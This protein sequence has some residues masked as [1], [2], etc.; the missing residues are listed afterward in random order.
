LRRSPAATRLPLLSSADLAD[1][2]LADAAQAVVGEVAGR[3][4]TFG[5]LNLLAE[6]HR[7][8]HGVRFS[9]P[10][11]RLAVAERVTDLAV[12]R[13][14]VIT[15]P[16]LCHTPAQYLRADGS[17]RLRPTHHVLYTSQAVLE[18]CRASHART[19][20]SI[21]AA[22]VVP[23]CSPR[24]RGREPGGSR[25]R[26]SEGG[27]R[28]LRLGLWPRRAGRSLGGMA[29]ELS[30]MA[31][32]VARRAFLTLA[33]SMSVLIG[34]GLATPAHV[35]ALSLGHVQPAD[36]SS[37]WIPT[38]AP[39]PSSLPSGEPVATMQL[40]STSCS[41][42]DFCV[43]VGYVQDASSD[44]YPLVETYQ[45]GVWTPSLLALP[46]NT[47]PGNPP[48][49]QLF[50]VSCPVDGT[51]A[52]VGAYNVWVPSEATNDGMGL[53]AN[54]SGGD[55]ATSAAPYPADLGVWE[56]HLYSVSCSSA[57]VCDAIGQLYDANWSVT[58]QLPVLALY[59]LSDGTWQYGSLP[60]PP[61]AYWDLQVNS[62]S[63]AD[64]ADCV[65]VGYYE[66]D[67]QD[68]YGVAYTL[69]SGQW[70]ETVLPSPTTAPPDIE[71]TINLTSVD[72]PQVDYC[73]AVGAVV[74]T[75][76]DDMP[77]VSIYDGSAWTSSEESLPADAPAG[78][79]GWLTGVSCASGGACNAVGPYVY[80][81]VYYGM[82]LTQSA[83]GW[84]AA[85]A[86][87]PPGFSN[88]ARASA[89]RAT[90]SSQVPPGGVGCQAEGFCAAGLTDGNNNE[91]ILETEQTSGLTYVSGVS[92]AKG[93]AGTAVKITG[94]GF[95]ASD[96]V[97]F[98]KVAASSETFV[99]S[100]EIEASVPK[101]VDGSTV[102]V[103][104]SDGALTSG[105]LP[106]DV[107]TYDY[108]HKLSIVVLG[109][110][111]ALPGPV[112]Y[113]AKA[114]GGSGSPT[115]TIRISDSSGTSCSLKL[116]GGAGQCTMEASFSA[117]ANLMRWTYGGSAKYDHATGQFTQVA[118]V[119]A[120]PFAVG[121]ASV[122]AAGTVTYSVEAAGASP[123]PTGLVAVADGAGNDCTAE[124]DNGQG[125]CQIT[126]MPGKSYAVAATY[127]G[128]FNYVSGAA[129]VHLG[130]SSGAAVLVLSAAP[131]VTGP[132]TYEVALAG[133]AGVPTGTVS[134]ADGAGGTCT[135]ELSGG[136]GSCEISERAVNGT[137]DVSATYNGNTVYPATS[138]TVTEPILPAQPSIKGTVSY[139][140]STHLATYT[141]KL[142]GVKGLYPTGEVLVSVPDV[143]SCQATV[144]SGTGRCQ[145]SE[146]SG[147]TR[148]ATVAYGGD[149]NYVALTITVA[150]Q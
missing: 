97:Y 109:P 25:R 74:D 134:I 96:D 58:T 3:R 133:D 119:A 121:V 61:A 88:G 52:A 45:D 73:V 110:A 44:T 98:G 47:Q 33:A 81:S 34:T 99:S 70:T 127:D 4:A 118:K 92:P 106:S 89:I 75:S 128:D 36:S 105:Q 51:C 72:C 136:T 55:W 42:A 9:S 115:G 14:L 91:G 53:L 111:D 38:A 57:N 28:P 22:Q 104:V 117:G 102:N 16:P 101:G 112:T 77:L 131:G 8:L 40:F 24:I 60:A 69:A 100:D 145:V 56:I 107:F 95:I 140:S 59:T 46:D 122:T 142:S 30:G 79:Q 144:A 67:Q 108:E 19:S 21:G 20:R 82:V 6:A 132:V 129:G 15:P 43:S 87:L 50:S 114:T 80:N 66:D 68:A 12:E 125:T 62:I 41:S 103:S 141:L 18:R 11:E 116:S 83:S 35:G 93:T 17:S 26:T 2:L 90:T 85:D 94:S 120:P 37:N 31:G 139:S 146:T 126:E 29:G 123:V 27:L 148:V 49:G 84:T 7:V 64:D 143:G 1:E 65:A 130:V 78:S 86:P 135:V 113:T 76:G 10:S 147:K 63:C 32:R 71:P 124:L 48:N 149:A 150:G 138:T 23:R 54:L 137:L 5:R 39:P 13:C